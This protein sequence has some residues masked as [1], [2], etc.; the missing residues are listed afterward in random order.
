MHEL[1]CIVQIEA[2]GCSL[3]PNSGTLSHVIM[4]KFK[5]AATCGCSSSQWEN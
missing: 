5:L 2:S 4:P 1:I 3:Y